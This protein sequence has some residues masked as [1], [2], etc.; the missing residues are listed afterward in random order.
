[1]ADPSPSLR[2]YVRQRAEDRPGVYRWMGDD[3]RILY[4]GKSI[5]LKSRLLSYFRKTEGKIARL[6]GKAARVAWDYLPNEFAA[7]FREMQM[8][9]A[10]QPEY[11][12]EHKRTRRHGFIKVTRETAPRLVAVTQVSND[13]AC[14]YGP[15]GRT[16]WL[17]GAVR[18]LSR[19]VGLRDC[20]GNTPVHFGDQIE[21]FANGIAP[22]CM[23]AGAGTCLAPCAG[24]CTRPEYDRRL[25]LARAFLE[26]RSRA[27]L[28]EL[29]RSL[30]AAAERM[31]YEYAA[32]IRDRMKTLERLQRHLSG[33]RGQAWKLNLVYS[34]PGFGSDDRIYLVRL[35]RLHGELPVPKTEGERRRA[36]G[37]I[38]EVFRPSP[39]DEG[40]AMNGRTAAQTLLMISWFNRRPRERR[41][42][43]A[44]SRWL[45]ANAPGRG[46]T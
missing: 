8:I 34:V 16:A 41:R 4:V 31:N 27:P 15:F 17:R 36:A 6:M 2:E 7:L 45:A 23:R 33:F 40:A 43:V 11:N 26:A 38:K 35:G 20:S 13:G 42:A 28:D 5:R 24:H 37:I 25:R 29:S 21:M 14:Y 1:M 30:E 10:W 3:G 44:P 19:V 32:T 18:D 39:D 9:H 12:V 46:R 22:R